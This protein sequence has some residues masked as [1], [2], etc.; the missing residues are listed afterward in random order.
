MDEQRKIITNHF[1]E[2]LRLFES[3]ELSQTETK[4]FTEYFMTDKVENTDPENTLKYLFY[5]YNFLLKN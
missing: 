5:I 4:R 2:K 1:R 3:G